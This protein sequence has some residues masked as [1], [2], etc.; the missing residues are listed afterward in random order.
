MHNLDYNNEIQIVSNLSGSY[1]KIPRMWDGTDQKSISGTYTITAKVED[2]EIISKCSPT[3]FGATKHYNIFYIN[4]HK[5]KD[6]ISTQKTSW[7]NLRSFLAK[8]IKKLVEND[9]I[10]SSRRDVFKIK[11]N[12]ATRMVLEGEAITDS[13]GIEQAPESSQLQVFINAIKKNYSINLR[14]NDCEVEFG[15]PDYED[16]FL[17]MMFKIGLNGNKSNLIPITH[18]GDGF[19][20]MFV[21]AV[22][23]AIAE[24]NTDDKCLFLFEEPESFLHEN[25][26]EYFYKMVLCSLAEKGHQVIYTTHSDKMVDIFETQ[27]LIRLE[28][29]EKSDCNWQTENTFNDISKFISIPDSTHDGINLEIYNSYIKNIEP[30]LN[31]IIFSKKVLFVEGPND[32]M[33]YKYS[34]RKKIL[35]KI[36]TRSDISE[37]EKYA[38]TYLSF[39]NIAIIPHHGKSTVHLLIDLCNY[40]EIN[41]YVITD[42]DFETNFQ[43]DIGLDFDDLKMKG[44]WSNIELEDPTRAESTLKS[45]ITVNKGIIEKVD[46]DK[47]HFNI[48]KLE[49][50][51]GYRSK[52]KNSL[53]IWKTLVAMPDIPETL[54]PNS[55]ETFL[56]F[57]KLVLDN[58]IEQ[59]EATEEATTPPTP[60]SYSSEASP[61]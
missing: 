52:D 57:D 30:N 38:D 8:H 10:M 9:E 54:F 25:H 1:Y 48:S 27:A 4:F 55:L 32:V 43:D 49:Q 23:Q 17:Q 47:L 34:I 13:S 22:I 11:V 26:Q 58:N 53:K 29:V 21:M 45:M 50:V 46:S 31:K 39:L 56:E 36:A 6:E 33:V 44:Y 5:I 3:F 41:F 51:I 59:D 15:L 61:E 18:F 60:Q 2:Q 40:L 37:K 28:M 12:E 19:I 14:N 24:S 16:I 42:W 7:G 20:S 35:E